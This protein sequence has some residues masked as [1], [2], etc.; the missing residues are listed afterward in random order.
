M[1]LVGVIYSRLIKYIYIYKKTFIKKQYIYNNMEYDVVN[2]GFYILDD[3]EKHE[4][5]KNNEVV[6][7]Y[8]R[9]GFYLSNGNKN[10]SIFKQYIPLVLNNEYNEIIKLIKKNIIKFK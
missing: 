1:H 10:G 2:P 4:N 8:G 5:I 7:K 9:Y 6:L 3:T